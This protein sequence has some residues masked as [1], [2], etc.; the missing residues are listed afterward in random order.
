MAELEDLLQHCT[1][2]LSIPGQMGWGTG[3]FVAPGLILTC[4]H[5]VQRSPKQVQVCWQNQTLDAVVERSIPDS[6]DLALLR[7]TPTAD[8]H[9]PC[10]WLDEEVRS[11][12][13]LYLFGYPDEGDRQGEPRTFNCDG[14]TGSAIAS[15]LF[16]LGQVRP[17]MSGS[18]L[19]NQRTGKV[20]G[21]VKFTRDRSSDLGGGAIPTRVI[22]EQFPQ[23]RDLQ[24]QA[25][26]QDLRWLQR[27][28]SSQPPNSSDMDFQPYQEAVIRHY[29][30]QRYLYT[31]TDALLPLDA[32]SVKRQEPSEG[33]EQPPEKTVEQFP[34]LEG[35]RKYALGNQREHVLL[36]GRPGSGKSTTLRQL[37]VTLA[38]EG[39]VPVLVQLKGDRPVPELIQAEFRRM[40]QRVTPEQVDDWLLAERLVL[41]LD[42]VNEI[43]NDNLRRSLAQFREENPTVPMIFTT[44]DLSLGSDLGI[45]KR[46]EMKPLSELQMR[47]FVGK[48]LPEQGDRLLGQLRDRLRELAETPLLLKLLCDMFDPETNQI[49]QNRGELFRWFDRDY[50]RIKKEIEYVPVSENFWEYKSEILQYLAFSMIQGDLQT[51]DIQKPPEP[52]LTITKSRAEAILETWLHQRG[53][54][55]APTKAKLWLKDLCNHH[56]L[57]DAVKPEEIEFHHQLFQEYYAAEYLLRLLPTLTYDQLKRDYLNYLKWTEVIALTL[58]LLNNKSQVIHAVKLAFDVDLILGARLAGAVKTEF[59]AETVKL[60]DHL[61]V[62]GLTRLP[63]CQIKRSCKLPHWLRTEILKRTKSEAAAAEL[64]KTLGNEDRWTNRITTWI[65]ENWWLISVLTL[66][67][68][69]SESCTEA[70]L[71]LGEFDSDLVSIK[72]VELLKNVDV[73]LNVRAAAARALGKIGDQSAIPDLLIAVLDKGTDVRMAAFWALGELGYQELI[74][75]L[76]FALQ[77]NN[78]L[79]RGIAA[80]CLGLLRQKQGIPVLLNALKDD[81]YKKQRIKVVQALGRIGCGEIISEL[82]NTLRDEDPGVRA[83]ALEAIGRLDHEGLNSEVIEALKSSLMH[84]GNMMVRAAAASVLGILRCKEGIPALLLAFRSDDGFVPTSAI[85]ALGKIGDRSVLPEMFK[86]YERINQVEK[87]FYTSR[88]AEL[89]GNLGGGEVIS[90]LSKILS[91]QDLFYSHIEAAQALGKISST[92]ASKYLPYLQT[93]L[94]IGVGKSACEA[95]ASIQNRCQF[96]NYEI[97]QAHLAAQKA[98][99]TASQPSDRPITYEVNAEVVQIVENNY[100]TIHGKQTP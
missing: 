20:C 47:E 35:L 65:K 18:P 90:E 19:L 72:L 78:D 68:N 73:S 77:S 87:K 55:D 7:L 81:D 93:F 52:W 54:P 42:G 46:L 12:D 29:S 80:T 98:D 69:D 3:F 88:F 43:P 75:E 11:R 41:L 26:Q 33:Q 27:L 94:S 49:P 25:H 8:V 85:W 6:Y 28:P 15:I 60:I 66:E 82:F 71:A 95:I 30:Q 21:M 92:T 9:P 61:T 31:P 62:N 63:F 44:R 53:V 17:G 1:V 22:L 70:V 83:Y 16:N 89:L 79:E 24:R 58:S 84:D 100:G 48:Y 97:W 50:K 56:F 23:L 57:Q 40:K 51:A 74:P 13:P 39:Q 34:V 10:V 99:R 59:Q 4:A 36:A 2:K 91:N 32:Q 14:T 5:V 38:E 96:Y 37:A 67:H 86:I 64:L 76:L 45:G